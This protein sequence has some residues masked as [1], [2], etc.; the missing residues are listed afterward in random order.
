MKGF[1]A[2]RPEDLEAD[3]PPLAVRRHTDRCFFAVE[4]VLTDPTGAVD[5]FVVEGFRVPVEEVAELR[6]EGGGCGRGA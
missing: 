2:L 3:P 1:S 6:R 5:G 4:E